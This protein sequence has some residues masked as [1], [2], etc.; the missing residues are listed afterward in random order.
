M[1]KQLCPLWEWLELIPSE[2]CLSDWLHAVDHGIGAD[3]AG[4]ILVELADVLPARA[5]KDRVA[6]LWA[7][8]RE[9]YKE[10]DVDYKL[11]NL[12]PPFLNK[13]S[14]KTAKPSP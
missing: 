10:Y 1:G 3:I 4:Q 12:T 9:L 7:E 6:V 13:D 5:I 8:I 14:K 11:A 2:L